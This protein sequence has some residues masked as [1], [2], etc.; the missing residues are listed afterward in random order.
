MAEL[1]ILAEGLR[2]PEGPVAMPDGSV[3]VVEVA[4]GRITRVAPD[5]SKTVVAEPGD[6]PNGMALGPDGKLYV[7]NNGGCFTWHD[8][9]GMLVPGAH[10]PGRY[11]GGRIERID[12]NSGTVEVL[13]TECAGHRL[14]AP[15]DIVFDAEGGFWFTDHG[16][17]HDRSKSRSAIYYA[18]TDGSSIAE[19]VFPLDSPNGIA[20]SPDGTRLYTAETFTG[21]VWFWDL[22]APGQI[23]PAPGILG[24]GGTV[25][26]G[27]GGERA[28]TGLDSMAV[29]GDG[30]VC[31]ATLIAGGITAVSPDHEQVEFHSTGDPMT[32]NI[33]FG[34]ADLG[35]AF[36][37]L[38]GSG[39]L[40]AMPWPRPGLEPAF[41]PASR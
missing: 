37:T 18:A 32:T 15:N 34:G 14:L 28:F 36:V 6:G 38:S 11:R 12:L 19:V 29:D 10:D 41:A 9:D 26:R 24:H 27:L 20:L 13:Y 22:A 7:C 35:T 33:C 8:H 1:T 39:R 2:F 25:L 3:L 31:V 16:L 30:W 5:R 4:A 40:A 21:R 23:V 17:V